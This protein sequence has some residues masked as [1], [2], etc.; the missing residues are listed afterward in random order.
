MPFIDQIRVFQA[1][2]LCDRRHGIYILR[3][4][5]RRGLRTAFPDKNTV[6]DRCL[7]ATFTPYFR[8]LYPCTG[9]QGISQFDGFDALRTAKDL[10]C[11]QRH[12]REITALFPVLQQFFILSYFGLQSFGNAFLCNDDPLHVLLLFLHQIKQT[13]KNSLIL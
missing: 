6:F 7:I 9:D 8:S 2:I 10:Q 1:E 11:L 12:T 4:F 13:Q 5:H 3:G